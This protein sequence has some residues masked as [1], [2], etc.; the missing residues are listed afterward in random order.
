MCGIVHTR[1]D[2]L[3]CALPATALIQPLLYSQAAAG[4]AAPS[5]GGGGGAAVDVDIQL[6]DDMARDD[7]VALP[8]GGTDDLLA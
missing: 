1:F 5:I 7:D 3:R 4:I 8:D 2:A 6:E